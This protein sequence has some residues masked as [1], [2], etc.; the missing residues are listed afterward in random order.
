MLFSC[1]ERASAPALYGDLDLDMDLDLDLDVHLV[2][3]LITA[4]RNTG[5]MPAT[6]PAVQKDPIKNLKSCL[7]S[8]SCALIF[9][10]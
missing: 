2:L 10:L 4:A 9:E 6:V 3:F 7:I 5:P 1:S 8:Q